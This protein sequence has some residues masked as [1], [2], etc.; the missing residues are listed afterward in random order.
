MEPEGEGFTRLDGQSH[1]TP[2]GK[3]QRGKKP[4]PVIA[5]AHWPA[6]AW[7]TLMLALAVVALIAAA[8]VRFLHSSVPNDLLAKAYTERRTIE[9][10]IPGAR[11]AAMIEGSPTAVIH[12]NMPASLL[13]AESMLAR[14]AQQHSEDARWLQSEARAALLEWDYQTATR[15]LEDALSLEPGDPELLVDRATALYEKGMAS[16]PYGTFYFGQAIND[17]GDALNKMPGNS[18]ALFNRAIL[19]EVSFLPHEAMT[20]LMNYLALD[21]S[22]EWASEASARLSRLSDKVKS[23]E[24][25]RTEPLANAKVFI[26]ISNDPAKAALIDDRIEEY[27]AVAIT[28]WLPAAFPAQAE[29]G[30]N[31][32]TL[33]ALHALG[34]ILAEKHNDGW[35]NELIRSANPQD[36]GNA[37]QW[38][39]KAVRFSAHGEEVKARAAAERAESWFARAGSQP[40]VLRARVEQI[41]ALRNAHQGKRCVVEASAVSQGLKKASY[42]WMR[43]QLFADT[44]SCLLMTGEFDQARKH[45]AL[46]VQEASKLG[47]PVLRLRSLGMAASVESDEGNLLQAWEDNESGLAD[48]WRA[49]FSPPRRAQQF[50]DDLSYAAENTGELNLALSLARESVQLSVITGDRMLEAMT[51]QHLAQIAVHVRDLRTAQHELQVSSEILKPVARERGM[52]VFLVAAESGLAE[53]ELQ[54]GSTAQAEKRLDNIHE[55]IEDFQSFEVSRDYYKAEAEVLKKQDKLDSAEKIL[56]HAIREAD[57]YLFRLEDEHSRYLWT[58][59]NA[60]LYRSLVEVEIMKKDP[61]TALIAWEWYRAGLSGARLRDIR[62]FESLLRS[63]VIE[64]AIAAVHDR[65]LISY[66]VL[67][68]GLAVWVVDESGLHS[69][70]MP[71]DAGTLRA[72][73]LRFS[74]LCADPASDR[75]NLHRAGQKLFQMLLQPVSTRWPLRRFVT[76]EADDPFDDI[77]FQALSAPDGRYFG[78]DHVISMSSGMLDSEHHGARRAFTTHTRALFVGSTATPLDVSGLPPINPA[79]EVRTSSAMFSR[80]RVL[81]GRASSAPQIQQALPDSEIVHFAGHALATSRSEG[82]AVF[83][84]PDTGSDV[85]LWNAGHVPPKSFDRCRLVVLSA[86][87]TGR[88]YRGRSERRGEL[89]RSFLLKGVPS[90]VG[91]RWDVDSVT[92]SEFMNIFYRALLSGQSIASSLHTAEAALRAQPA[93]DHPYY[94]AAFSEFRRQ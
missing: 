8:V 16:Q 66:A 26:E 4:K 37:V 75:A 36:F 17:L 22:G 85:V 71:P 13:K 35:L 27:L 61:R 21:P 77:S 65:S 62:S 41:Y 46:A 81:L 49:E 3:E 58:E 32:E 60:G 43:T 69:Q 30:R 15:M 56:R 24:R 72:L 79:E 80:P 34:K 44:C 50:Y 40:G 82:I 87:S 25:A 47:Y 45:A 33:A 91:S 31:P 54:L 92:T 2:S 74:D 20:D 86:C 73:A 68:Q 76:I 38:L 14:D 63:P 10:R 29:T 89:T 90:V 6:W 57:E 59:E 5:K 12:Q 1:R 83:A 48:Y 70:I 51:R 7:M 11:H 23:R 84:S 53:I 39:S 18:L 9:L 42:G 78:E 67:P 52:Q 55:E 19:Y 94:W 93:T 64:Q 88:G 28:D